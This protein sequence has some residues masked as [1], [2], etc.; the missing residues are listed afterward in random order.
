MAAT[1]TRVTILNAAIAISPR[2]IRARTSADEE[3]PARRDAMLAG[4]AD[5][6]Q[7]SQRGDNRE[8]RCLI[9]F[10]RART[11]RVRALL[12][13]SPRQRSAVPQHPPPSERLPP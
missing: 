9:L 4:A 13:L 3:P 5:R 7:P 6:F 8:G 10:S 12:P 11:Y 1:A 2:S